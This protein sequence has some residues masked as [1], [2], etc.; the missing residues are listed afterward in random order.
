MAFNNNN[1][2]ANTI[3]FHSSVGSL[4]F[5][6][7]DFD[8]ETIAT[9][10]SYVTLERLYALDLSNCS[11]TNMNDD[12]S[13]SMITLILDIKSI[14]LEHEGDFVIDSVKMDNIS[15]SFLSL[16]TL[17]RR[18]TSQKSFM[19]SNVDIE[20]SVFTSRDPFILFGP[21]ISSEDVVFTIKNFSAKDLIFT[22]TA[23][24]IDLKMQ[25]LNPF[26]I[27]SGI[28]ENIHGGYIRMRS[29]S[30][31]NSMPPVK[32]EVTNIT[33]VNCDSLWKT[34]FR[35]QDYSE[36]TVSDSSMNQ[37]SGY[38]YGTVLSITES[39]SFATFNNCNFNN[40]NGRF[41]GLFYVVG[42]SGITVTNSNMVNNFA[43]LASLIYVSNRGMF[44]FSS[45]NISY[46]KALTT[47]II[48]IID[49]Q[50]ESIFNSNT[51]FGNKILSRE[52]V[53][54]ELSDPTICTEL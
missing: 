39:R 1:V 23:N 51:V 25:I 52:D 32:L 2:K 49:S 3:S 19:M 6:D 24:I 40:N 8:L 42:N 22:R 38:F 16:N 37:N 50:N 47:V 48:Q 34:F 10:T 20:N 41:G 54:Y 28:F 11:F 29:Q 31:A 17:Y 46:N 12:K 53:I 7:S 44:N 36:L 33:V 30:V 45:C 18:T 5:R 15:L 14:N 27:E 26:K 4:V 21:L 9:G 43:I 13:V 35:I